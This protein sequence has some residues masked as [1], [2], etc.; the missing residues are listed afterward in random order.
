MSLQ[1]LGNATGTA[2]VAEEEA[3][4]AAEDIIMMKGGKRK[5]GVGLACISCYF[6]I[7]VHFYNVISSISSNEYY[8]VS[9][10]V[11]VVT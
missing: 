9:L 10:V 4:E 1:N 6:S 2:A 11:I 8:K 3:E 7:N 5:E